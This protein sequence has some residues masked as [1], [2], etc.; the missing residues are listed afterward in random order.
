MNEPKEIAISGDREQLAVKLEKLAAS[1]RI[2]S[3]DV[4]WVVKPN[5]S[6]R[7]LLIHFDGIEDDLDSG[8]EILWE[9]YEGG[10]E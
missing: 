4:P 2:S 7:T 3:G 5:G 10:Y 1:L 8:G 9:T 6:G